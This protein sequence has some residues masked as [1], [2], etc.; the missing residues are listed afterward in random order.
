MAKI[1]CTCLKDPYVTCYA[2]PWKRVE[3]R[4]R[5]YID[6]LHDQIKTLTQQIEE[7]NA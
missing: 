3:D 1:E 2:H 5:E 6:H 4:C 7:N